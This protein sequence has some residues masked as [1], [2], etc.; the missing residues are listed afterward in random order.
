M[1]GSSTKP[2]SLFMNK[3]SVHFPSITQQKFNGSLPFFGSFSI[4]IT[5]L[6]L[7]SLCYLGAFSAFYQLYYWGA[8][9]SSSLYIKFK[10][11]FNSKKYLDSE[12]LIS[13][14]DFGVPS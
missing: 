7:T 12:S 8:R 6:F 9:A 10:S 1:A 5:R 14:I 4:P 11:L 2:I 3:I 13:H